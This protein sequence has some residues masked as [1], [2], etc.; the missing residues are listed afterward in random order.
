MSII[1]TIISSITVFVSHN[2][3]CFRY[4]ILIRHCINKKATLPHSVHW[5]FNLLKN[6]IHSFFPS[7]LLN[8][9]TIQAPLFSQ[10]PPPPSPIYWLFMLSPVYSDFPMNFHETP[11]HLLK[12][13]K[14]LAKISQ[15][16]FL[17][18]T[19]K[20]IYI[21]KFLVYLCKNCNPLKKVT[22]FFHLL[23]A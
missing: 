15:F 21:C 8:L 11:L 2:V 6:I 9:Q 18:M 23:I 3:I 4:F 22:P 17:V 20:N 13:P 10:F 7:S 19:R 14:F 12:V 5:G 1:I 16:K